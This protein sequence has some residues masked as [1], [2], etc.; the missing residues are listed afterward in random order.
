MNHFIKLILIL[1]Q[2]NQTLSDFFIDIPNYNCDGF[3]PSPRLFTCS[4]EAAN[5]LQV[6]LKFWTLNREAQNDLQELCGQHGDCRST[7][8]RDWV[9]QLNLDTTDS[10]ELGVKKYLNCII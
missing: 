3:T 9:N 4:R 5:Q 7:P 2:I 1:I 8:R 10:A 6:L